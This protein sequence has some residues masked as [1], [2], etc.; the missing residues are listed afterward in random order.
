[1]TTQ[2]MTIGMGD[3]V[4]TFYW[5]G[6]VVSLTDVNVHQFARVKINV[7]RVL[8]SKDD[9]QDSDIDAFGPLIRELYLRRNNGLRPDVV[10]CQLD[11]HSSAIVAAI[12]WEGNTLC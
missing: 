3:H 7:V 11:S 2:R 10:K 8:D 5:P 6:R 4:A 1:V 9:G 12:S